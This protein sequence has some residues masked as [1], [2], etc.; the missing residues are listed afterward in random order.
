MLTI[1]D[2]NGVSTGK[3]Y[4]SLIDQNRYILFTIFTKRKQ[5]NCHL[6]SGKDGLVWV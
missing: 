4:L 2:L 1:E 3:G 5:L 6:S